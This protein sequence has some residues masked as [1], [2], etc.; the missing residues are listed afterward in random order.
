MRVGLV[1][2]LA[3]MLAGCV[4][5]AEN[6]LSPER[7]AALKIESVKVSFA[8]NA[9]LLWGDAES[10]YDQKNTSLSGAAAY[11][12][13]EAP[14]GARRAFVEQKAAAKITQAFQKHVVPSFQGTEPARVEITVTS[15]DI[16]STV[17]RVTLGGHPNV[18]TQIKVVNAKTGQPIL[19]TSD[20]RG[21]AF[22]GNGALAV[23]DQMVMDDPADRAAEV[24]AKSYR[25]WLADGSSGLM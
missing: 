7:R 18:A 1:L 23:F 2:L 19:Q 4:T 8:P 24:L 3:L 21:Q 25:T 12:R 10:E 13:A 14:T 11:V 17:R 9:S 20:F 5:T 6:T 15:F 22:A 16:P